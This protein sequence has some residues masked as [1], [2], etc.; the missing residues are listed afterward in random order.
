[1]TPR[2][3][4]FRDYAIGFLKRPRD[5]ANL[6]LHLLH[7]IVAPLLVHKRRCGRQSPVYVPNSLHRLIVDLDQRGR[8][9]RHVAIAGN[10]RSYCFTDE[11]YFA[12]SQHRPVAGLLG[13]C[14]GPIIFNSQWRNSTRHILTGQHRIHSRMFQRCT[15]AHSLKAR[16]SMGTSHESYLQHAR[17]LDVVHVAGLAQEHAWVLQPSNLRTDHFPSS[18]LSSCHKRLKQKKPL[19]YCLAYFNAGN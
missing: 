9:F 2:D 12:S 14:F 17:H 8:I 5:F 7:D 18:G 16:M 13:R 10:N 19:D 6:G 11:A 4:A 1:M 3:E 15:Y